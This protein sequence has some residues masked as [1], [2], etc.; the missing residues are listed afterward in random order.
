MPLKLMGKKLGMTSLFDKD[1]NSIVCT[2]IQVEPN[3]VVQVK[4]KE[5]DGYTAIQTGYEK[6]KAKNERTIENRVTKPLLGHF[7]KANVSPR[8]HLIE[9]RIDNAADFQ[10]G[11]EIGVNIFSGETFLDAT[12]TSIGKGYQGPMKLHNMSGMRATHGAGPTHRHLGS[13]GMRSTPGRCFPGGRRASHMGHETVTVQ[14]LKVVEVNEA[15]NLIVV[16]GSIPGPKNGIVTLTK[17]I[18]KVA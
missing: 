3:V 18:K 4:T 14:N 9:S 13:T 7:K 10:V 5:T 6:I 15:E 17:A 2:V 1:G 16:K 8:R 12:A 11:Q